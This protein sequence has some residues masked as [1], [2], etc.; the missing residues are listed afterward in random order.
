MKAITLNLDKPRRLR[1]SMNS[2]VAIQE[3][4]GL[5][6]EDIGKAFTGKL[7]FATIR[8][9]LW[10]MLADEPDEL[11]LKQ[12]GAMITPER[13]PEIIQAIT[14]AYGDSLPEPTGGPLAES[15]SS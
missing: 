7:K 14:T 13:L 3:A 9:L 11:T 8:L 2:L 1:F 4:T 15:R 6:P 10:A 5:E 12:V